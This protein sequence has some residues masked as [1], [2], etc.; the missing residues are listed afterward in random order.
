MYLLSKNRAL[1]SK[2]PNQVYTLGCCRL[3]RHAR[4]RSI[5]VELRET[6][7]EVST[8]GSGFVEL[9]SD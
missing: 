3:E 5:Q 8:S 6:T 4:L 2:V 9:R 1:Y 7:T